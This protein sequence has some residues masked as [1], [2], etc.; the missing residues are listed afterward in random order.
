[1]DPNLTIQI[2]ASHNVR[3][4]SALTSLVGGILV[5]HEDCSRREPLLS[6]QG[7]ERNER[8]ELFPACLAV[9]PCQTDSL[10]HNI[11]YIQRSST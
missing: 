10:Q 8:R 4:L 1:M 3:L 5:G 9:T 2:A 11:L 7:N 6:V